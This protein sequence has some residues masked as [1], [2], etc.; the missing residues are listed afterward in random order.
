MLKAVGLFEEAPRSCASDQTAGGTPRGRVPGHEPAAV[1]V[2]PSARWRP[3]GTCAW[4]G[5]TT[6]RSTA[7]AARTSEHP[8]LREGLPRRNGGQAGA[9]LPLDAAGPRRGAR[10]GVAQRANGDEDALPRRIASFSKGL[11]HDARGEVDPTAYGFL[12]KALTTGQTGRLR[13]D[14]SG[15]RN[16]ARQPAG[17]VGVRADRPGRLPAGDPA[18]AGL[19]RRPAGR[20][21]GGAV[22]AGPR[23][24]RPLRRLRDPAR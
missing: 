18:G 5:T 7:G 15:R 17:R 12:L 9:E 16:E 3:T 14:P 10:R 4:W 13:K 24:R 20:R 11:P 8:R 23:A 19:R 22:L 21:N 1:P 2:G 6:S